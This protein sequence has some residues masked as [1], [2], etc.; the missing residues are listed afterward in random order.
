MSLKAAFAEIAQTVKTVS[1]REWNEM[2]NKSK[3]RGLAAKDQAVQ[4]IAEKKDEAAQKISAAAQ[5]KLDQVAGKLPPQVVQSGA[6]LGSVAQG[7][8][9]KVDQ[10]VPVSQTLQTG[11]EKASALAKAAVAP[12]VVQPTSAEIE[13]NS[14]AA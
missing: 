6:K 10:V 2:L 14:V 8:T 5:E 7:L 9:A 13:K 1:Q 4:Q 11:Q 12:V 3:E